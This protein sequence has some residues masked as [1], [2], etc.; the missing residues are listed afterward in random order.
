MLEDF[1]LVHRFRVTFADVDMLRHANNVAYLRWAETQRTEYFGDVLGETIG[2]SR[3]M[4]LARTEIVYERPIAY[5]ERVAMG[6][7]VAKIGG[8]S[9]AFAHEVWS[10]DRNV[11][12]ATIGCT[13]VAFDYVTDAT[14]RVP[15]DWREKIAAYE[16]QRDRAAT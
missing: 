9:F 12:C 7:R 5:R 15:D 14:I 1:G 8:K 16:P 3:G 4:I 2:G 6:G 10:E 13:L 11:R